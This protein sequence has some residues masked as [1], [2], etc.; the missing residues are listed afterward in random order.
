LLNAGFSVIADIAWAYSMLLTSPLVVTVGLSLTIPLSLIGQMVIDGNYPS[1][2]Y[3]LGACVVVSSFAF[4]S[5]AES[6]DRVGGEVLV[7]VDSSRPAS[8][9]A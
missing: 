2:L 4:I 6:Q 7:E 5:R 8:R 1:W 3:W 9:A